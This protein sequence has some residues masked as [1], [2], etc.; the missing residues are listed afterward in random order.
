MKH[1][2]ALGILLGL[3][4]FGGAALADDADSTQRVE[5]VFARLDT[6]NDGKISRDEASKGKRLSR[7]FDAVDADK[8]GFVTRAELKVFFDAH[9]H[10][11]KSH[12]S[13]P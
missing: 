13:H 5:K 11:D 12:Q 9:P 4:T 2:L 1:P 8:D 3:A 6:N 7:H 10:H